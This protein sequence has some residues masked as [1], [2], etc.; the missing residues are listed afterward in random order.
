MTVNP[1]KFQAIIVNGNSKM[2]SEYFLNIG[3]AKVATGQ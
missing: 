2:R 3:E 1:D